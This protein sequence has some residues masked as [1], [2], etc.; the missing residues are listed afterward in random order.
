[1]T[2][3]PPSRENISRA[4]ASRVRNMIVDVDSVEDG[5]GLQTTVNEM[6]HAG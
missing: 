2:R 6:Q 1:M 5:H 3:D 4:D